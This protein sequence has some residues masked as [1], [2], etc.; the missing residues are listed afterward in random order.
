MVEIEIESRSGT[1]NSDIRCAPML[2]LP[3]SRDG[4]GRSL[5]QQ[6]AHFLLSSLSVRMWLH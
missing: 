3:Y 2:R 4:Y 5:L 6:F 1:H